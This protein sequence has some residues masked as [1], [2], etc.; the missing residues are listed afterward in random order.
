MGAGLRKD[1]AEL[2]A[3]V[4]EALTALKKDGTVD[5]LIAQWFEGRGPYFAE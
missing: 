4:D 1:E 2:K 5:R 3:K